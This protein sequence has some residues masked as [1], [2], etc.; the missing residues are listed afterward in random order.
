MCGSQQVPWTMWYDPKWNLDIFIRLNVKQ[1]FT[2]IHSLTHASKKTI[3]LS[4]DSSVTWSRNNLLQRYNHFKNHKM[5]KKAGMMAAVRKKRGHVLHTIF[6]Y[7]E[8]M[9]SCNNILLHSCKPF[10]PWRTCLSADT[11]SSGTDPWEN[12]MLDNA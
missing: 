6:Y 4:T 9:F 11:I 1:N 10:G 2:D 8:R 7:N 12:I 5:G 3:R